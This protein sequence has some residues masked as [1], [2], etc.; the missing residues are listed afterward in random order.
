MSSTRSTTSAEENEALQAKI[1]A[2]TQTKAHKKTATWTESI[3]A[4]D[5][6][7]LQMCGEYFFEWDAAM[8]LVLKKR[9]P[10]VNMVDV[11]SPEVDLAMKHPASSS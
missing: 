5:N 7:T 4:E 6:P 8:H 3:T 2:E 10:G 11:P 1:E 9:T